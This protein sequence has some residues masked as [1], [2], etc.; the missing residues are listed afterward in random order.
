MGKFPFKR[1]RIISKKFPELDS[2]IDG[3]TKSLDD[4][5]FSYHEQVQHALTKKHWLMAF[6]SI[7]LLLV[8]GSFISMRGRADSSIFYPETCL[9]GWINP[10]NAQ[11]EAQTTSNGDETQFTKENSA[12]LPKNTNAE[13][14]CGNF[15]GKFDQATRPTKIIVSLALTK[16]PEFT[17]E[18]LFET[19]KKVATT[20]PLILDVASSTTS[21][22]LI[23]ASS[24]ES[25]TSSTTTHET[26]ASSTEVGTAVATPGSLGVDTSSIMNG[27]VKSFQDTI[28]DIFNTHDTKKTETDTI[29]VPPPSEITPQEPT[30][31]SVT[32]SSSNGSPTSYLP[33]QNNVLSYFVST[34]FA[35]E[36]VS[37][38]TTIETEIPPQVTLNPKG[39]KI[40]KA[41]STLEEGNIVLGVATS[42]EV[43]ST[44]E[45]DT[46]NTVASST[47][48]TSTDSI[49]GT[50]TQEIF[51]TT[52]DDRTSQN[53]FLEVFYTFD[54][55]VWKSL[56]SLNEIS[57]KYRTFEIPVN[58]ST[59]WVDMSKLQIKIEARKHEV[60]TPV[61]YLDGIKVEVLYATT[62]THVH[63]DFTRDT[64]LHD[65][66]IDDLRMLTIINND[67]KRE[68][69][70][71]MY[72]NEIGTSTSI[73]TPSFVE[74]GSSTSTDLTKHTELQPERD[75]SAKKVI[76][77]IVLSS[78]TLSLALSTI[79]TTTKSLATSS[80]R[81]KP[82]ILRHVWL[83]F[84]GKVKGS[85]IKVLAEEIKK[86]DAYMLDG[87]EKD[88]APDFARDII[89]KIH[90][91]SFDTVVFQ[92][93][94]NNQE[95]LWLYNI[96]TGTEEKIDTGS[97]TIALDSPLGI[98]SEYIFWLSGDESGVIAYNMTT[99]ERKE[100]K[101]PPYDISKGE[102]GEVVFK[103]IPW[104]VIIGT[105]EFSFFSEGTGEVFSDD[106][107][108][109][110]ELFRQKLQLD[111]VLDKEELSHL[112]LSV[113][114]TGNK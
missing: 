14:Y 79:S 76:Q 28:S 87:D 31:S 65:E 75:S 72:L 48:A 57:M 81:I 104:K 83:K 85:L 107:G 5:V 67:S 4:L 71:Y 19:G 101:I 27:V 24:S 59:S 86:M 20:S 22:T 25:L 6:S 53:N 61:V 21:S 33:L 94:K 36:I 114:E 12:V 26:V 91:T 77:D 80:L 84:R 49:F 29:V 35:E 93:E 39:E 56:G 3:V 70:W 98:K 54:G 89:K 78:S 73:V 99:H 106:N 52:T 105:E 109:I 103:N 66:T 92:V 44:T 60:D 68:E 51:A 113:E 95:E 55:E 102:R 50:S 40:D 42:T 18:D 69:I 32:P 90:G 34:A 16:G 112:N 9:G 10:D 108:S 74:A 63:P 13:M 43:A 100:E 1:P 110:L 111:G 8:L 82:V 30:P 11:G 17:H 96:A 47:Q 15:K 46:L 7:A 62:M 23:L 37:A 97:S 41:T 58:A 2:S 88:R 45:G 64:I 38:S